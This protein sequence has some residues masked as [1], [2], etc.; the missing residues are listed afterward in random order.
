MPKP[1]KFKDTD[2]AKLRED[3]AE[4][5]YRTLQEAIG[6]REHTKPPKDR[7]DE[8]KKP[9]AVDRGRKGGRRGGKART[10]ALTPKQR[11]EAAMIAAN[12]RWKKKD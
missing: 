4:T 2:D 7:S 6:E 8:D 10:E 12:A 9:E 5:A 1:A 3:T 11:K